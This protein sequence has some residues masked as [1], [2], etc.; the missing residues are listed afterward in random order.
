MSCSFLF[1]PFIT[2]LESWMGCCSSQDIWHRWNESHCAGDACNVQCCISSVGVTRWRLHGK[3][4]H[5]PHRPSS[6]NTYADDHLF[7][8][9]LY[10]F[11]AF[12][13]CSFLFSLKWVNA[14]K[15]NLT[16]LRTSHDAST[17]LML[18]SL[19]ALM[20]FRTFKGRDEDVETITRRTLW[21][22]MSTTIQNVFKS[23]T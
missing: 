4:P 16:N 17:S 2:A 5:S 22:L 11:F 13:C 12:Y 6:P 15:Q 21:V 23:R 18:I 8:P 20:S 10:H 14:N 7:T 9:L 19:V 1:A 3:Q